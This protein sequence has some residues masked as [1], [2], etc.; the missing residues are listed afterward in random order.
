M[1]R[2]LLVSSSLIVLCI[3]VVLGIRSYSNRLPFTSNNQE[4][5]IKFERSP[6][7]GPCPIY[8]MI[9]YG[10]GLVVYE[11]IDFV[12]TQGMQIKFLSQ[13]EVSSLL[14]QFKKADFYSLNDKY[15]AGPTD[16]ASI[17]LTVNIDGVN[18]QIWHYGF[19]FCGSEEE[20]PAPLA[21]CELEEDL[22]EIVEEWVRDDT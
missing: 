20:N 13:E 4:V 17:T 3:V 7:F 15:I 12:K 19:I 11:G 9:I 10:S 1:N 18:K 6:C 8:N 21:L 14:T 16:L 2:K 22:E 5:I